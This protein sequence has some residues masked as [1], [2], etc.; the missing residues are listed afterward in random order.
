MRCSASAP[1]WRHPS[2]MA[3]KTSIPLKN[4]VPLLM[5]MVLRSVTQSDLSLSSWC[6]VV[7]VLY[8]RQPTETYS[9]RFHAAITQTEAVSLFLSFGAFFLVSKLFL[10]S[11]TSTCDLNIVSKTPGYCKIPGKGVLHI[12][13]QHV[14]KDRSANNHTLDMTF[15]THSRARTTVLQL[16]T[17]FIQ[18]HIISIRGL[19]LISETITLPGSAK[20]QRDTQRLVPSRVKSTHITT[21]ITETCAMI[22]NFLSQHDFTT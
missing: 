5:L 19:F 1:L 4:H 8:L 16:H 21:I 15:P 20:R 6:L 22:T 9:S 18:E 3:Q 13:A 7:Q 2:K 17:G 12:A 14:S 11:S 10:R